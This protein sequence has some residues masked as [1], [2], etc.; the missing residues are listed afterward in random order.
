M[1]VSLKIGRFY[2]PIFAVLFDFRP[3]ADHLN[4]STASPP[5]ESKERRF[6]ASPSWSVTFLRLTICSGGATKQKGKKSAAEQLELSLRVTFWWVGRHFPMVMAVVADARQ[7]DTQGCTGLR[8]LNAW[9][10]HGP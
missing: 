2:L 8:L 4:R 9:A 5:T 6:G 1:T 10:E 7:P 3:R